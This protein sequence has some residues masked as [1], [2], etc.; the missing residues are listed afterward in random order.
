LNYVGVIIGP[1]LSYD[2]EKKEFIVYPEKYMD[3]NGRRGVDDVNELRRYIINI[4]KTLLMRGIRGC[5]VYIVDKNLRDYFY[6]Y[7]NNFLSN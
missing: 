7:I 4:Y 3:A 1:E 2:N 6:R 5:Y